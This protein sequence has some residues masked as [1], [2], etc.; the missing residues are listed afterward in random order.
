M[1]KK[2]TLIHIFRYYQLSDVDFGIAAIYRGFLNVNSH[3]VTRRYG[4]PLVCIYS[5]IFLD[6]VEMP[7]NKTPE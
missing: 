6:Y 2:D 7:A 4:A 1:F 5:Y 3:P